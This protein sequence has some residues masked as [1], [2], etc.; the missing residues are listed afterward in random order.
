MYGRKPHAYRIFFTVDD[1]AEV[2]RVLHLRRGARQGPMAEE[3]R[4]D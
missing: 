1:N 4:G 2:V 3:L